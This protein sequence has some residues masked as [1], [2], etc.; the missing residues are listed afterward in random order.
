MRKPKLTPKQE[1]FC[2]E[3]L[4]DL[5]ATQ[6]AIRAG[7]SLKTAQRI[8]SENLSKPLIA[9]RIQE[10]MNKR[11]EKVEIS[12]DWVLKGIKDLT[13]TLVTSEDPSKAYKGF[14]LAGRHLKLF[15]DKIE[16]DVT[17]TVIRKQYKLKESE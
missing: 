3:Y 11:S 15:T 13:D 16:Q 14:E 9:E 12:A 17:L 7:Y 6:A 2:K 8:G 5:N 10:L 4:I 1:M